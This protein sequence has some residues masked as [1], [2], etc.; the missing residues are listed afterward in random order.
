MNCKICHSEASIVLEHKVRGSYTAKLAHCPVCDFLF[1]VEP[2]W[3]EAAYEKPI[4]ATDTGYVTRN[5]YLSKKTLI[6]F[7]LLFKKTARFV[8]YAAGY[9]M[10]VRLMR[11]YGLDFFWSDLYTKNLFAEGFE[12]KNRERAMAISCFECFEHL[13]DPSQELQKMLA[14]SDTILFSTKLKS[15]KVPNP[16]WE[17]YGWNHGQHVAFYSKRSLARLAKEKGLNFYTDGENLHLF[18]KRTLPGFIIS[19]INLLTKLQADIF[20][21]KVI[22]SKTV[23]D[24]KLLIS[25]GL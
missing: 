11:D 5:V 23:T 20:I 16:D 2:D 21:R 14:I 19:F 10:L 6:L 25:R 9:G 13:T 22:M 7:W 15:S 24:Q 17:Y 8:D 4:N 12:H 3:L 18:T 1:A